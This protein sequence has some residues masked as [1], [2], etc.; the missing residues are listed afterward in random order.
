MRTTWWDPARQKLCAQKWLHTSPTFHPRK[1]KLC[2]RLR[3][4]FNVKC[5]VAFVLQTIVFAISDHFDDSWGQF[6]ALILRVPR[7]FATRT[8]R[9]VRSEQGFGNWKNSSLR[10][11][12]GVCSSRFMSET[13]QPMEHSQKHKMCTTLHTKMIDGKITKL[14]SMRRLGLGGLI[15]EI[16]FGSVLRP[17]R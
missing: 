3:L 5:W 15:T 14:L 6:F 16:Q 2:Q 8:P 9:G 10:A 4:T 11:S 17:L 1:T 12:Y 7:T 13:Y